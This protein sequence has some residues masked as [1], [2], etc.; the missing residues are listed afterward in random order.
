MSSERS[1]LPCF[2]S[3]ILSTVRVCTSQSYPFGAHCG[4]QWCPGRF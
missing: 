1:S 3:T 4:D 2:I